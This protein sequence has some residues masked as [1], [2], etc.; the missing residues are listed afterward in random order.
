VQ[1]VEAERLVCGLDFELHE[2]VGS[3]PERLEAATLPAIEAEL[4]TD[5]GDRLAIDLVP[6]ALVPLRVLEAS[7]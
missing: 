7:A 4:V 6:V 1:V 5:T 3:E 2:A